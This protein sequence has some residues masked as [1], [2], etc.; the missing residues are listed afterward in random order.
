MS[1][2]HLKDI[3]ATL[4]K[5]LVDKTITLC[6][7]GSVAASQAPEI[8]REL[9]RRGADVHVVLSPAACKLIS[10][11][12]MEWATGNPV[13]KELTGRVEHVE[14]AGDWPGKS[15]LVLVA[16]A[17]ANTIGKIAYGI[18]DT[19]VTT[20]VTTAL[21][22]GTPVIIAPAMHRSMYKHPIVSDNIRK[23][24]SIGIDVLDPEIVEGKA[25]II[26]SSVIVDAVVQ[27]LSFKD[28]ESFRCL[29]T[30]GPTVEHI[31][32]VRIITNRSSGR[33]GVAIARETSRR[34][35]ETT[36]IIGPTE[37]EIPF[38]IKTIRVETSQDML[39]AV[40]NELN[41]K[42]YKVFIGS[43]AV[44]D[45]RPAIS[46]KFK[47]QTRNTPKLVIELQATPKIIERVRKIRPEIFIVAFKAEYGLTDNE[48]VRRSQ[49]YLQQSSAD[50]VVANHVGVDGVGFASETNEVFIVDRDLKVTHI[51]RASK[52][53]I[54]RHLIDYIAMKLG[55][56]RH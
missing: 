37:I 31:D 56:K 27:K 52:G 24:R 32:P 33:M 47:I 51:S 6:V 53:E 2:N 17:T 50:L 45:Y 48:L 8:A 36:L 3:T 42:D 26:K 18:D 21:G 28:L 9:M 14:L 16:P 22:S 19:P 38:N 7:T 29:V 4:G 11:A 55:V 13:I 23:L 43:A 15:D 5:E 41:S 20:V 46:Q 40:E 44:T 12:L 1:H 30:A 39:D 10:P 35:A 54:A 49:E 34:G 25:K